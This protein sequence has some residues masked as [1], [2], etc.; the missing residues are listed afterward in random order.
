MPRFDMHH[1][2]RLKGGKKLAPLSFYVTDDEA[3]LAELRAMSTQKLGKPDG[4]C[5]EYVP[6]K[7][8][9]Q[10]KEEETVNAT[11]D[12]TL[13]KGAGKKA[14]EKLAREGVTTK[15]GLKAALADAGKKAKL[16][17]ALGE[18]EVAKL[19]AFFE[20]EDKGKK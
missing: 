9:K 16:V 4:V 14:V 11:D 7:P 19:A 5:T 13:V 12:I 10:E 18:T 2:V 17:E 6:E 8:K 1:G 3:E 15:S 20:E